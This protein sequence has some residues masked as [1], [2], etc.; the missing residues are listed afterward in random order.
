MSTFLRD[1]RLLS[2]ASQHLL[3]GEETAGNCVWKLV[4]R[5]FSAFNLLLLHEIRS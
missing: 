1:A 4:P 3:R 5:G 2:R